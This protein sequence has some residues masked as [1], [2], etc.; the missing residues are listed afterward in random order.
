MD[1]DATF[2]DVH[3]TDMAQ[4]ETVPPAA[5][6]P[7]TDDPRPPAGPADAAP[8]PPGREALADASREAAEQAERD[9]PTQVP[10]PSPPVPIPP[11]TPPDPATAPG[12]RRDDA[13]PAEPRTPQ[14]TRLWGSEYP[15]LSASAWRRM[16]SLEPTDAGPGVEAYEASEDPGPS[17]PPRRAQEARA[18]RDEAIEGIARAV[19]D[20]RAQTEA[21]LGGL[22][23]SIAEVATAIRRVGWAAQSTGPARS[24][25]AEEAIFERL[26]SIEAQ[27]HKVA[28]ELSTAD[29]RSRAVVA[30]MARELVAIG[31]QQRE[32]RESLHRLVARIIGRPLI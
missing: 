17:I 27:L 25:A 13:P 23:E 10:D 30:S 16:Q 12:T 5:P 21:R 14:A 4:E 26:R 29:A 32:L 2:P 8:D 11:P 15:K 24:T 1:R 20:L 18:S 22:D 3:A 19:N 31:D 28:Q 6:R 7:S 9:D